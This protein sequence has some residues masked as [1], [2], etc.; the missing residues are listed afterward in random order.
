MAI[1]NF[2]KDPLTFLISTSSLTLYSLPGRATESTPLHPG[3][4]YLWES[5][6]KYSLLFL[7]SK[8]IKEIFWEEY[9]PLKC[10]ALYNIS[11]HRFN[12]FKIVCIHLTIFFDIF[13]LLKFNITLHEI[14]SMLFVLC[15]LYT[16][17]IFPFR[18]MI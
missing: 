6:L 17:Q 2:L 18:L 1:I 7:S 3:Y 15:V 11:Y 14:S 12:I 4:L 5:F 9:W 10:A 8:H 13:C 16:I